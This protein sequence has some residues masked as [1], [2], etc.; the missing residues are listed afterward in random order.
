MISDSENTI[1]SV[2]KYLSG[3]T[4]LEIVLNYKDI[5]TSK[6]E[7]PFLLKLQSA[8]C[9]V[10]GKSDIVGLKWYFVVLGAPQVENH[11]FYGIEHAY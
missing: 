1:L 5:V 7:W 6:A 11:W 9:S 2:N 8:V 4:I 10:S 3:Y